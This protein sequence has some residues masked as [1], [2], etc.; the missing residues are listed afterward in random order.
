M[1]REVKR[2]LLDELP[3]GDRRAIGS[4]RDLQKVNAWMGHADIMR[5]A[6]AGAFADR[7]P[8]SIVELGAGDGTLL[9]RLAKSIA[10]RW[11]PLRVVLVDRQRLL[12]PR[13]KAEFAALSWDVES[14]EMDVF[15]WLQRPHPEHSD[16]TLANLFL[17][18]FAED[19][20]RRLV[21]HA[22]QQT[23]FFLACEPQRVN[24]S[25]CAASLLGFIGCNDV[26]RHDA[27]ISVRA[28]FA[29]NELS[30]LWPAG[31]GWRLMERQ[32]GLFTHCFVAQRIEAKGDRLIEARNDRILEA[33]DDRVID[34]RVL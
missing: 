19:D 16:V 23:G 34:G 33:K 22:A 9:L 6:L 18:H 13:T 28:G 30:T 5:R 14:I 25:L 26:S 27:K 20:L 31:D 2:E 7:S 4:R 21:W 8:R 24:F 11:K 10:P 1:K 12:S 29:K 3:A 32:A 15:D 17:H